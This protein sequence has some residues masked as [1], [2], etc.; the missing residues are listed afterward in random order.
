MERVRQILLMLAVVVPA[1]TTEE[2]LFRTD[3][4]Q[5]VGL[6]SIA[7]V[8]A[9]LIGFSLAARGTLRL[10]AA[11]SVGV[12]AIAELHHVFTTFALGIYNPGV[13]TA[14]PFVVFGL[15]VIHAATFEY[16]R[17]RIRWADVEPAYQTW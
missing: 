4:Q 17:S 13:V 14:V 5:L 16:R 8:S 2:L 12:L 10:V 3:Q 9:L 11:T 15:M 7:G 1:H 6:L